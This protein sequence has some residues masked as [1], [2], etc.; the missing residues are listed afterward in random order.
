M[1]RKWL[2]RPFCWLF[3]HMRARGRVRLAGRDYVS[4]CRRCGAPMRRIPGRIWVADRLAR[5][6]SRVAEPIPAL[7]PAAIG[8]T[9]GRDAFAQGVLTRA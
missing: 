1:P 6:L 5:S 7:Q 9:E 8:E 3:G 4:D 2:S